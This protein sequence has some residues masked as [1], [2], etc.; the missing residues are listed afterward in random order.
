MDDKI[1]ITFSAIAIRYSPGHTHLRTGL[2]T[3]RNFDLFLGPIDIHHAGRAVI[4]LIEGNRHLL[5]VGRWPLLLLVSTAGA[6]PARSAAIAPAIA[7]ATAEKS[8]E[9][10][11]ET[12]HISEHIVIDFHTGLA[13]AVSAAKTGLPNGKEPGVPPACCQDE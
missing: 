8:L 13:A 7:H 1:Q 9:E 12:T 2:Y 10:I 11:G 4:S 6:R 3:G 5:L